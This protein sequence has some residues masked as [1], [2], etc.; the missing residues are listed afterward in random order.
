[1][2][3]STNYP[4]PNKKS[5]S[6]NMDTMLYAKLCEIHFA[7]KSLVPTL[8]APYGSNDNYLNFHVEL[9]DDVNDNMNKLNNRNEINNLKL[10]IDNKNRWQC[11]GSA[12][13]VIIGNYKGHNTPLHITVGY[14]TDK[15]HNS[16]QIMNRVL[17]TIEKATKFY[18]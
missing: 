13:C 5:V 8:I 1:M 15:N 4:H 17:P 9:V 6:I 18:L 11:I 16:Q 12:I 10:N 7:L 2:Q 3:I 14:N